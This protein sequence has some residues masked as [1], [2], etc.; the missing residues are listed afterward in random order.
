[1]D[2]RRFDPTLA[3]DLA[4]LGGAIERWAGDLSMTEEPA[5]F[6]VALEALHPADQRPPATGDRGPAR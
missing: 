6:L 4:Y 3:V 2:A 1:M 5:C